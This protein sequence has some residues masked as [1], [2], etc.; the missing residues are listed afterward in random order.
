MAQKTRPG[1][2]TTIDSNL[3]DNTTDFIT[4]LLHREE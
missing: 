1:L 3:P 4:P 2:Q